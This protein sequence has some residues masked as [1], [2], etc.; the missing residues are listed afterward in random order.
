[1]SVAVIGDTQAVP[2][3]AYVAAVSRRRVHLLREDA[4][5]VQEVE[6]GGDVLAVDV[7]SATDLPPDLE[8]VVVVAESRGLYE[9]LRPLAFRLAGVPVLLAPGGFAGVLR[10]RAWFEAWGLQAP[11]VAE[12]TGFP[13]GGQVVGHCLVPRL[14][15]HN[16]PMAAV[17]EA[18][19]DRLKGVF[20]GLLPQLVA[21]DPITTSMSNTNHM[22]HPGVVLLN[23]SRV[24]N[25]EPFTFYRSGL[26]PAVRHLLE[27]VDGERVRLM[28]R[29]GVEPRSARD[30]L[31]DFYEP[32]GMAGGDI[33]QCLQSFV[34]FAGVLAPNTL[35]YRYLLDDVPFG[36]AQWSA[37]AEHLDVDVPHLDALLTSLRSLAPHLDLD[38]D[39]QTAHLFR[40]HLAITQG[41]PS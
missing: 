25:G 24:D 9:L 27:A 32:E 4:L 10:V 39:A 30:W 36:A 29:L 37:L 7:V 33:V 19:T 2:V 1:M 23:A 20:A 3:A 26:S 8:A 16:L 15:K 6:L 18:S 35:R 40:Q 31:V 34:P 13:V 12:A 28:E 14:I 22:I 17:D 41:V 21:S 5:R 11:D 38:P